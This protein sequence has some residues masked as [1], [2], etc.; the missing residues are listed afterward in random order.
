[1]RRWLGLLALGQA[2]HAGAAEPGA[3]D[4]AVALHCQAVTQAWPADQPPQ[5]LNERLRAAQVK[6]DPFALEGACQGLRR[7]QADRPGDVLARLRYQSDVAAALV[8]LGRASEAVPLFE[9]LVTAYQAAGRPT[10]AAMSAGMLAVVHLQLGENTTALLWS[11]QAFEA[12][13]EPDPEVV[14]SDRI[15]ARINHVVMLSSARRYPEAERAI[16]QLFDEQDRLGGSPLQRAAL[17]AHRSV[18]QRRQG[19]LQEALAAVDAEI[20]LRRE[21][22]PQEPF[23]LVSALSNRG[24]V[25]Q[26]LARWHESEEALREGVATADR[27]QG[28]A[29]DISGHAVSVR[30]QLSSLLLARG[31]PAGAAEVARAA[32]ALMAARPERDAAR[33]ARPWRRLGEAQLAQ[34]AL[35]DGL[36]SLQQALRRLGP[37]KTDGDTLP[38]TRLS[39]AR[40]LLEVGD[41]QEAAEQLQ[42]LDADPRPPTPDEQAFR[43]SL[44]A[45]ILLRQGGADGVAAA[46]R[47]WAAADAALAQGLPADHPQRQV[48]AALRCEWEPVACTA[49][50][51][52][53]FNPEAQA[54]V[55]MAQARRLLR[56]GGAAGGEA[57]AQAAED[58]LLAAT[59]AGQ[60]R[61]QWQALDLLAQA[62]DLRGRPAQAIMLGKLAIELLQGQREALLPL[63]RQADARYLA[64]KT[65]LYRRVAD[66]LLRAGRLPEARLVLDLLKAQEQFDFGLRAGPATAAGPAELGYTAPE[67][68]ARRQFELW[69]SQAPGAE[70]QR[71]RQWEA[72]GRLSAAER[73][74]LQTL[75]DAE[76]ERQAA[77]RAGLDA[78][79]ARLQA[80]PDRTLRALPQRAL[81]R[82]AAGVLQVHTLA[83]DDA[84]SLLFVHAGGAYT[85]RLPWGLAALGPAIARWRDALQQGTPPDADAL[86]LQGAL[87]QALAQ[88]S[89]QAGAQRI[90]LA[91]DGPLRYLPPA[92]L[93][94]SPGQPVVAGPELVVQ[95]PGPALRSPPAPGALRA[96]AFGVT[97]ALQ[98]LPAL[99]GV[100]DEL[101]SIV[102]GSVAGLEDPASACGGI[103]TGPL[104][105]SGHLNEAFTEAQLVGLA[106]QQPEQLLHLGTHFVL[107][108][109]NVSRSWLLLGDGARLHLD[110]LRQLPLG[111]PRL[112]TLSAC[113]T[114]VG[115]QA[116]GREVDGLASTLIDG[117]AHEVVASLW[118]VEDAGTARFMR[119]F[120]AALAAHRG[121]AAAAL[122]QAQ[123]EAQRAGEPARIW[124]AFVLLRRAD[125]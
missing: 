116:D 89:R 118:R 52:A 98:G 121:Q 31:D 50:E 44:Q 69:L 88:A 75:A 72:A 86:A 32:V 38:L 104:P 27:A 19:R 107:R 35:A 93:A 57:A 18:L 28:L 71:L 51:S 80:V 2:L 4:T 97:R 117:G 59:T 74:R 83:G 73:Q 25:L 92:L 91:L 55:R 125:A 11:T 53:A 64:D 81:V 101:C 6:A 119:R 115:V 82:P 70:L 36:A 1:M 16:D 122:R 9:A 60:P 65:P 112:V 5:V 37:G 62:Q 14:E 113:E 47:H 120:Y 124:A 22:W 84:L 54:V 15:S 10:L 43:H 13:A 8:W 29:P 42:L 45:A 56:T 110:R 46:L 33:G 30:E 99:P 114:A 106:G 87:G 24:V 17:Y 23:T 95:A 111:Q 100:A 34:G 40:A 3:L 103:G 94:G 123:V 78:A 63:G 41:T 96:Q 79:L 58:A 66:G 7:V 61:L 85:Q 20:A 67:R 108:P 105:G 76:R 39:A 77:R 102:Q 21:L 68:A 109:G 49:P 90:V 26:G 12:G 48:L